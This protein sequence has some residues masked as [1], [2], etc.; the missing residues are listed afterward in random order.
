[1]PL[2]RSKKTEPEKK[3][4]RKSEKKSDKQEWF[5]CPYCFEKIFEK[6][7]AFRAMTAYTLQDL[8]DFEG[9]EKEKKKRYLLSS[10]E[11]YE[12]FWNKYPGSKPEDS[13][14]SRTY[15]RNP[16][17]SQFDARFLTNSKL[18][19][20]SR[21]QFKED[22]DG[23][24]NE[25][26][27]TEGNSSKI[28]ICPH[29][30]NKLPFEF[31]K[32]PIKYIP[33]VGITSS[34]KTV[35]LSQLLGKIHEILI[36]ADM[37][38]AGLCPEVDEFVKGHTIRRG[39]NLPGGNAANVLT[40]P[41]PVNVMSRRDGSR[42]T[43]VF[44][45]IAG[46]NCVKADQMVKYGAFIKNADGIIMIMDP[47]QF[48]DLIY[49]DGDDDDVADDAYSP[50]KVV[51]AMY[52]AF[53]SSEAGGGRSDIPLAATLSKSDLFKGTE[54]LG[55]NSNI[56]KKI[57]YEEYE[58]RGF[59][60][61]DCSVIDFEVKKLMKKCLKGEILVDALNQF[62]PNHSFFAFSALNG[63]PIVSEEGNVKRYQMEVNPEAVRVEEPLF[64]LLHKLGLIGEVRK[65]RNR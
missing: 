38:V 59:P 13:E 55:E 23:F 6:G 29:C 15:E 25:V 47:G 30:H 21:L 51:A 42:H 50:N 32:Y 40:T 8:D 9:A 41:I 14:K 16:V 31:G 26:I 28:R 64:W 37:T 58:G 60:Y 34:G 57:A 17:I 63:T 54:V 24:L 48:T 65:K 61:D 18:T 3:P 49:L 10:D 62:F 12:R 52:T 36:R 56:F 5:K 4:E 53:V 7:V 43:L 46:E 35:F 45:D 33:V 22:A 11:L 27:D 44:Y 20:G 1:M 2:F 19:D 39:M